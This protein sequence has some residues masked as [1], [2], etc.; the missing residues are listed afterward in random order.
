[1]TNYVR[2]LGVTMKEKLKEFKQSC[3]EF[4]QVYGF[5]LLL[6]TVFLAEGALLQGQQIALLVIAISI[7]L[8]IS[9][10]AY[11]V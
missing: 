8:L 4:F 3:K 7:G 5:G 6:S 2:N 11:F 9:V 10:K 1:M